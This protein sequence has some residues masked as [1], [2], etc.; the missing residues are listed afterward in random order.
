MTV[1]GVVGHVVGLVDVEQERV[2]PHELEPQS[3]PCSGCPPSSR[4]SRGRSRGAARSGAPRGR[5]ARD[6]TASSTCSRDRAS[7][8]RARGELV[9]LRRADR[10]HE[11]L[12]VV[13]VRDEVGGD[14]VEELGHRRRVD[15][16]HVVDRV[17]EA[18][19]EEVPPHAI[20][21]RLGEPRVLAR[22]HPRRERLARAVALLEIGAVERGGLRLRDRRDVGVLREAV[23]DLAEVDDLDAPHVAHRL[24]AIDGVDAMVQERRGE[25]AKVVLLPLLGLVVVA[26]RALDLH[27]EEHARRVAREVLRRALEAERPVDGAVDLVEVDGVLVAL[28]GHRP[29]RAA[30]SSPAAPSRARRRCC[31]GPSP[32][33]GH[34]PCGP[35]ARSPRSGRAASSGRRRDRR[36]GPS[37]RGP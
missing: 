32:R 19:T 17:V 16:A 37:P 22:G 12:D 34:A 31:S 5:A 3:D 36:R 27:A 7:P 25:A 20:D 15:G 28:F 23:P 14:L 4:S 10:P 26:L 2:L 11:V 1:P 8:I 30:R 35:T 21:E 33:R 29:S 6:G 18:A 9:R 13:V 24:A